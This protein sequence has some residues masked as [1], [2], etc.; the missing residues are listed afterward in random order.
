MKNWSTT[1]AMTFWTSLDKLKT[2][3]LA[4]NSATQ[5]TALNTGAFINLQG[6]VGSKYQNQGV[7]Y[8]QEAVGAVNV[9]LMVR[10]IM[11]HLIYVQC[12]CCFSSNL[13]RLTKCWFLT[14]SIQGYTGLQTYGLKG[15]N[16]IEITGT[17]CGGRTKCRISVFFLKNLGVRVQY[18]DKESD[19]ES[20]FNEESIF[21]EGTWTGINLSQERGPCGNIFHIIKIDGTKFGHSDK[22][23]FIRMVGIQLEYSVFPNNLNETNWIRII[24]MKQIESE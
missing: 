13:T 2:R 3:T 16:I 18:W 4:L 17:S 10:K 24:W 6:I 21:A 7:Q 23:R 20:Q 11:K 14:L 1:L 8:H 19:F 12:T 15:A 22:I 5:Q 9:E